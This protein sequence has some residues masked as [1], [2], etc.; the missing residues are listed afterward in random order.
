M[1]NLQSLLNEATFET[2]F[3]QVILKMK[4]ESN[5]TEIYNQIRGIKD[6]VVIKVI[7]NDKLQAAS[8]KDYHYSLLNLKFI[9]GGN[10]IETIKMIK[11]EALKFSG[12][13]KFHVRSQTLLKIRNY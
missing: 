8:S 12:L 13:L 9:V 11:H 4:N 6:V 1:I 3:V 7:D 2:Y 10:S 5:F